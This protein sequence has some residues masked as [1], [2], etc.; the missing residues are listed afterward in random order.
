MS[1][2]TGCNT[3]GLVRQVWS[4][5]LLFTSSQ[6]DVAVS[7]VTMKIV[8]TVALLQLCF[9]ATGETHRQVTRVSATEN[10]SLHSLTLFSLSS[11]QFR[12]MAPPRR[13]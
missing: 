8:A 1:Q 6:G 2:V 13:R 9:S 11:R 5:R 3:G 10:E 4:G 12:V 7:Q